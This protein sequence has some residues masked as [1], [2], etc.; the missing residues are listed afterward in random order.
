MTEAHDLIWWAFCGAVVLW[1][2]YIVQEEHESMTEAHDLIGWAFY[3]AVGLWG[4]YIVLVIIMMGR[5]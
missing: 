3:G 5:N 2:V 4:V 1:G